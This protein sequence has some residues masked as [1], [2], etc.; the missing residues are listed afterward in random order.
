[1]FFFQVAPNCHEFAKC[2]FN[3]GHYVK[4]AE[5]EEHQK[6]CKYRFDATEFG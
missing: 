5:L 4:H 6:N 1:M 2:A 3:A